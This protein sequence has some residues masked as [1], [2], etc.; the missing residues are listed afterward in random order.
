[1]FWREKNSKLGNT[2]SQLPGSWKDRDPWPWFFSVFFYLIIHCFERIFCV[3]GHIGWCQVDTVQRPNPKR[4]YGWWKRAFFSW[5]V[6]FSARKVGLSA[7]KVNFSAQRVPFQL[8]YFVLGFGLWRVMVRRRREPGENIV[9]M[10]KYKRCDGTRKLDWM[11]WHG[12]NIKK[13]WGNEGTRGGG[14]GL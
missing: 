6:D 11:E 1:M 10:R 2:L 8:P 4:K 3:T 9:T 5:K 14:N 13:G 7:L 12:S